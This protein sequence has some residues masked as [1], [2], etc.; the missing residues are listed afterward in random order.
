MVSDL[1]ILRRNLLRQLEQIWKGKAAQA[2][3]ICSSEAGEDPV[4]SNLKSEDLKFGGQTPRTP[5]IGFWFIYWRRVD[6]GLVNVLVLVN[7]LKVDQVV[8]VENVAD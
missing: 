4:N 5:G 3:H 2:L 7:S 8:Q 1:G 6:E